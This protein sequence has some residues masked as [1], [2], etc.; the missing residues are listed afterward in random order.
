MLPRR[1][2]EVKA[3]EMSDT[4]EDLMYLCVL[5]K[6]V[7]LQGF[8]LMCLGLMF[9]G[10]NKG[11]GLLRNLCRFRYVLCRPALFQR[12]EIAAP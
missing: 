9:H 3:R 11:L 8:G 6:F 5:E 2:N 10:L 7:S 4:I 1:M 12:L